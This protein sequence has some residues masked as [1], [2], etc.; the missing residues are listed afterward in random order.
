M[1]TATDELRE[2]MEEL[3]GDPID[4]AGPYKYLRDLGYTEV[5]GML[6]KP[7]LEHVPTETELECI[8]FL[9]HEWDYAF[10]PDGVKT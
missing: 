7:S 2:R 6:I 8:D 1:P 9:F 3:F 4:M 5:G 10:D